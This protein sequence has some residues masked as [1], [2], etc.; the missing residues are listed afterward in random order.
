MTEIDPPVRTIT[1]LATQQKDP[2]RVSVFLDGAFA[3]GLHAEVVASFGLAKGQTLTEDDC[4]RLVEADAVLRARAVAFDYLA[5]RARTE[6]EVRRRLVRKGFAPGVA[7][8]VIAR[9]R[10]L[11]YLDDAAYARAYARSR[12]AARGYGPQRLRAEL[13]RRGVE[14]ALVEEALADFADEAAFLEEARRHA[15]RRWPRLAGEPD[16]R[17]RRRKLADYLTRR[18][19]SFDVVRQVVEELEREAGAT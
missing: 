13:L 6:A 16:A 14:P 19:F 15:R 7:E 3:F 10:A 12:F 5:H 8:E 18:G 4:A 11:G 9:L 1:R 2:D 17:K